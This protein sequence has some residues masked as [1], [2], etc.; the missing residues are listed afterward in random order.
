[1]QSLTPFFP[2]PLLREARTNSLNSEQKKSKSPMALSFTCRQSWS[3]LTTNQRQLLSAQSST[4]SSQKKVSKT[5]FLQVSCVLKNQNSNKRRNSWPQC[6][7]NSWS[8]LP[9][10]RKICCRNCLTQI[11]TQFWKTL[12]WLKVLNR[13]SRPPEKF[14]DNKQQLWSLRR[15][16]TS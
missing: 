7:T 15:T 10:S 3:I 14:K 6:K 9:S 13:Q 4:S 11:Q 16:L 5:S 12:L 1:M 2:V 8:P